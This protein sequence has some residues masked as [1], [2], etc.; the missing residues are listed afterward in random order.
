[1]RGSIDRLIK[2][3][4]SVIKDQ[5]IVVIH[6][7]EDTLIPLWVAQN[8]ITKLEELGFEVNWAALPGMRHNTTGQSLGMLCQFL[9]S[10]LVPVDGK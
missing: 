9:E 4:K 5:P 8:G 7:Q 1:M 3:D 10:V 6:G 2:S